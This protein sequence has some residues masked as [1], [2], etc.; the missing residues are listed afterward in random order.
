[1][2]PRRDRRELMAKYQIPSTA[3]AQVKGARA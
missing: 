1:V 3:S 2:R